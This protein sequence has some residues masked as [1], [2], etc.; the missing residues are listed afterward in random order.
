MAC[1]S[2]PAIDL[3]DLLKDHNII[4]FFSPLRLY[5][6]DSIPVEMQRYICYILN[7]KYL[8]T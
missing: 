5:I 1:L 7:E 4:F 2:F 6:K 8:C 3:E